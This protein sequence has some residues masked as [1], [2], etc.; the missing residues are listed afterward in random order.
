MDILRIIKPNISYNNQIVD[1]RNEFIFNNESMDG[2]ASL[3][4]FDN[5]EEWIKYLKITS[6]KNTCPKD[7]VIDSEFI[8]IR[9]SDNRVIGMINI[10][11]ELNEHLLNF[12]GNIG[13]SVRKSER[14]K[15]YAKEQ[16]RL[17]LI[18]CKNLGLEKVLITC[19]KN[20]IGSSKTILSNG[21]ILDNEILHEETL[22][23]TQRYWINIK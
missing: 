10:R 22:K 17:A 1:Y 7:R 14:N 6:N 3:I 20:N 12:G 9:E 2:S 21:G 16:L 5:A 11:H 23:I 13:Y 19:D 8:S 15:G 4:K 18:E